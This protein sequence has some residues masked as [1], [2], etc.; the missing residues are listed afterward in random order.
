MTSVKT[1]DSSWSIHHTITHANMA[2]REERL[3]KLK[4]DLFT[5]RLNPDPRTRT[6]TVPMEILNLSFPRTGSLC[7]YE[8][9][10]NFEIPHL[11]HS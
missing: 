9:K 10:S 3:A 7:A 2:T 6:R 1:P 5:P 11:C 8:Q 4:R